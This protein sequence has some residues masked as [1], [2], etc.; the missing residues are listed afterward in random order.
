M[1]KQIPNFE[2]FIDREKDKPCLVAGNAP[3]IK[4]FPFKSFKGLVFMINEGPELMKGMVKPDYWLSANRYYPIPHLH[5]KQ[6]NRF[7]NSVFIF[8]DTAVYYHNKYSYNQNAIKDSLKIP[9]FAFDDRHFDHK[10]CSPQR[11]CCDLVDRFP[12]RITLYEFV[13]NYYLMPSLCPGGATAVLFALTFAIIMGCSPIYIHGV[14]L[15]IYFKDYLHFNKFHFR[16]VRPMYWVMK[17]RIKG[18][19]KGKPEFS[20]FYEYL[21]LTLA[22]FDYL[23]K[24]CKMR[25]IGLYNLS[26][27]STLNR[28]ESLSYQ[29]AEKI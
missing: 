4:E 10:K 19:I 3:T 26:K 28:L 9:W 2:W 14:E 24:I 1:S 16:M 17:S 23:A 12:D 13:K 21:E 11:P 18:I 5:A 6:I 29:E 27:S 7:N 25:G 22:S 20:P 8:S 15:P